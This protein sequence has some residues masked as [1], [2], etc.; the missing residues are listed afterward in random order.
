MYKAVSHAALILIALITITSCTPSHRTYSSLDPIEYNGP[1]DFISE[2]LG[3]RQKRI[4]GFFRCYGWGPG[5]SGTGHRMR[6]RHNSNGGGKTLRKSSTNL[7]SLGEGVGSSMS[8]S[9]TE[10]GL[11][12]NRYKFQPFFTVTSGK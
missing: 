12:S 3:D 9:K 11:R 4:M 10:S 8:G 5:C 6:N 7:L 1:E 2:Q